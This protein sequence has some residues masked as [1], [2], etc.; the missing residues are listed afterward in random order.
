MV[1]TLSRTAAGLLLL[2]C[3]AG[4]IHGSVA[5]SSHAIYKAVRYRPENEVT[6]APLENSNRAEKS[7][8]L[9]PYNYYFCIWTAENCWYNRHDDDGGEIETR[10]LAAERWC[11]RGLE[12]NSRKSQLRLLKAR[13][14]ARRDARKAAEYWREYVDWDFWDSF[15]HAA[16]AELYA[17][18]GD[19]ES[20]MNQLKWL[21]KPSD[22]EYAR[23]E[24]NAAW[25]REMSGNP[26][27]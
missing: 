9:Y 10:V 23:N 19:I 26:G 7:Y 3:I 21:T 12:L 8:S 16:L 1:R 13:L 20:A 25:K 27:K 6:R 11:D 24:I 15:N 17:A 5:A 22:L 14:M 2:I 18:A 4:I